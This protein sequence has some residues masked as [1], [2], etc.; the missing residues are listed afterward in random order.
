MSIY[1]N[2]KKKEKLCSRRQKQK[3]LKLPKEQ[4]KIKKKEIG[5]PVISDFNQKKIVL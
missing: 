4:S 3:L 1:A 2:N 5:D